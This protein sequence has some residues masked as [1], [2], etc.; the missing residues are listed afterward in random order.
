MKTLTTLILLMLSI[1]VFAQPNVKVYFEQSNNGYKILA[2]N[3]EYCPVSV[4]INFNLTNIKSSKGNNIVFVIPARSKKNR[5]TNLE[6]T[7]INKD[8]NFDYTTKTNYGNHNKTDYENNFEYYLPF[9]KEESYTIYQ[10]YNGSFSHQ[11]EN[12]LDFTMPIGTEIYSIRDGIVVKVVQ[13]NNKACAQKECM[14]YNNYIIIYHSDGTFAEYTHIK[15]NGSKVKKGDKIKIGELIA[16]SG[17][18]GWSTGPHLHLVVFLQ[19]IENR[20]TLETKFLTGKGEK[21]EFLIEKNEY[22]R[23][24]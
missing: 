24:Y 21:A 1:S 9:K 20:K 17:N 6:I 5:I 12:A 4:E 16:Y 23:D 8:S 2:D 13:N 18:V 22:K 15:K 19:K 14:K 3:E 7:K 11:N 10:G